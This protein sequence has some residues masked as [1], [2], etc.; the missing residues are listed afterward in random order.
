IR[1]CDR[2][3]RRCAGDGAVVARVEPTG[4][5]ARYTGPGIT[6]HAG[7]GC[8]HNVWSA[9]S[10]RMA[11]ETA[12]IRDLLGRDADDLLTYKAKG[13]DKSQLHLPGPD[14][15]DRVVS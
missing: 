5:H 2:G 14:F 6:D 9:R 8:V 10:D 1:E 3:S 7:F 11:A 13:F 12:Q 15:I 4:R